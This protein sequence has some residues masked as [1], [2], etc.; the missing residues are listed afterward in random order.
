MH[1]RVPGTKVLGS[2]VTPHGL[3]QVLIHDA[4]IDRAAVA[5][6]VQVLKQ[7]LPWQGVAAPDDVNDAP[8]VDDD[9]VPHAALADK[10][11]GGA[12]TPREADVTAP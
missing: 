7:V 12:A 10:I 6:L 2:E 4:R 8:A 11:K 1:G 3:A 5:V 9:L